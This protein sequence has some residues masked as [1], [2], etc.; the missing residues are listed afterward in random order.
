MNECECDT[1]EIS[2]FVI[3]LN[4]KSIVNVSAA[5]TNQDSGSNTWLPQ[6]ARSSKTVGPNSKVGK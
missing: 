5:R 1:C 3:N 2:C 4:I 6:L